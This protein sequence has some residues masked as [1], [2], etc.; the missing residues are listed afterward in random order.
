MDG[1]IRHTCHHQLIQNATVSSDAD[2]CDDLADNGIELLFPKKRAA[3]VV[4]VV[5]RGPCVVA[6]MD[7]VGVSGIRFAEVKSNDAATPPTREGT[8]LP[9]PSNAL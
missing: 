8:E 7:E 4:V 5:L 6:V 9:S 1:W 2:S 3:I